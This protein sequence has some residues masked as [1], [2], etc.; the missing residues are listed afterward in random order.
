MPKPTPPL[1]QLRVVDRF[2][3]HQW[4]GSAPYHWV[5]DHAGAAVIAAER[6]VEVKDLPWSH[7]RAMALQDSIALKHR[8]G[9]N[10]FF[11]ALLR[12]ARSAADRWLGTWW[13]ALRC[14]AEWGEV[15]RP[16]GYGIWHEPGA[17]VR[18]LLEYDRGTESGSRLAQKLPGY[19]TL[20]SVAVSPTRLLFCFESTRREVE[21]RRVLATGPRELSTAVIPRGGSP[22]SSVWLPIGGFQRLRLGELKGVVSDSAATC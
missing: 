19:R 2:R 13:S 5:L 1:Y 8:V 14:A 21:A 12:E 4:P 17:R 16:D 6:G 9:C 15:V 18:F 10:G 20:L 7:E 3:P 11:T 22:A